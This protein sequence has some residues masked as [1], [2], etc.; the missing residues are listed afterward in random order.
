MVSVSELVQ[1][2]GSSGGRQNGGQKVAIVEQE[3]SPAPRR[4]VSRGN[5][6]VILLPVRSYI[7]IEF[8]LVRFTNSSWSGW[9]QVAPYQTGNGEKEF[10]Y[11]STSCEK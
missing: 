4:E 8:N 11:D 1:K 7:E 9:L 2:G 6:D 3:N 10:P 5:P